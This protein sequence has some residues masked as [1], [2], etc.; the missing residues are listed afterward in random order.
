MSRSRIGHRAQ[1]GLSGR[2]GHPG[3]TGIGVGR[4]LQIMLV[5]MMLAQAVTL[6][7]A[8]VQAATLAVNSLRDDPDALPGDGSCK[9]TAGACTL[10]AAIQEANAQATA[11]TITV[12]AGIFTT[13]GHLITTSMRIV[14][15]GSGA[16]I[17]QAGSQPYT[18]NTGSLFDVSGPS[19]AAEISDLWV[20]NIQIANQGSDR[21]AITSR[22]RST[23]TLNRIVVS[24]SHGGDCGVLCNQIGT[25]TVSQS[26]IRN[27]DDRGSAV[28]NSP[29]SVMTIQGSLI[30]GNGSG[31]LNKA[32]DTRGGYM[33][34][35]TS[36]IS[37]NAN[38]FS[39][40]GGGIDSTNQ[41]MLEDVTIAN[42]NAL[43]GGGIAIRN[44]YAGPGPAVIRRSTVL[45]NRATGSGAGDGGG[46]IAV[47]GGQVTLEN[48]TL[49][50]NVATRSGGG[51]LVNGPSA[52]L[53]NVT[54]QSND[55]GDR[56]GH[57]IAVLAGGVAFRNTII[58]NAGSRL[59]NNCFS[60]GGAG[61]L[62]SQGNNIE[63]ANTCFLNLS[64]GDIAGKTAS[65][66]A[67]QDN[68]GPTSTHALGSGSVAIDRG[69]ATG[70]PSL[71]Q[72][73]R[74][75]PRDGD[76]NGSAICDIGAFEAQS[77]AVGTFSLTPPEAAVA[78][79][80]RHAVALTWTV[81][82]PKTW[83]ALKAV[84]V[85]VRES[86]DKHEED[87]GTDG[88]GTDHERVALQFEWDQDTNTVREV[89]PRN[90]RPSPPL[91][92]GS[93]AVIASA[94]AELHLKESGIRGG[95]PTMP[96]VTFTMSL[97]FK[98]P[99]KGRIYAMEVAATDD[100]GASQSFATAGTISVDH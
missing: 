59:A 52:Q 40:A 17:V 6:P 35:R 87:G 19:T 91:A 89:D 60:V 57:S 78:V 62:T 84:Q 34:I 15:A 54:F 27:N 75:R 43:R 4:R 11:S 12:P 86:G 90:G 28:Y 76:G 46:G 63:F 69:S 9:T 96:N 38:P 72:R 100:S 22:G 65:L 83:H 67:L 92:F 81:P 39:D 61:G 64:L 1:G 70:C 36:T 53:Q 56:R 77:S 94:R 8:P 80:Q 21:G 5:A 66:G 7:A 49:S 30:T 33:T 48:V 32:V 25:M 37:G 50:G 85:R 79:G 3:R 29:E 26:T 74:P 23:L 95:G 58:E 82:A 10:R 71:D 99:T 51:L 41:L 44:A 88:R 42:N 14:G 45:G 13:T 20:R 73:G 24:D 47:L 16:T 93:D 2:G 98:Q 18:P 55:A 31:V 68:G 97:G